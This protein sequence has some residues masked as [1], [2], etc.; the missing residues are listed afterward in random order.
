MLDQI[1]QLAEKT[2]KQE[3]QAREKAVKLRETDYRLKGKIDALNSVN[4]LFEELIRDC[5]LHPEDTSLLLR[6]A[7]QSILDVMNRHSIEL[8]NYRKGD[9]TRSILLGQIN[10]RRQVWLQLDAIRRGEKN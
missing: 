5:S 1:K 7:S 8:S 4:R 3:R 2:N 6:K 9:D 10:A